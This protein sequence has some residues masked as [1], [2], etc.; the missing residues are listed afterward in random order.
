LGTVIRLIT[1]IFFESIVQASI[2]K[3]ALSNYLIKPISFIWSTLFKYL[4]GPIIKFILA[5]PYVILV[6]TYLF[7]ST[8]LPN[9]NLARGG[10]FLV[11]MIGGYLISAAFSFI[12]GLTSFWIDKIA[13]LSNLNTALILTLSGSSIPVF[14]FPDKA[15]EIL[16]Y[17]PFRFMLDFQIKILLNKQF[18]SIKDLIIMI[19]Y[20]FVLWILVFLMYKKGLQKYEAY[21]N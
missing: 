12:I 8:A 13:F 14:L 20:I 1:I 4:S 9:L 16:D 7:K 5:S 19:F 15:I 21:G 18:P 6:L 10:L 11:S 3:G 17:L 2:L